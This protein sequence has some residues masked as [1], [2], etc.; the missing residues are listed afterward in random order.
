MYL[1]LYVV[2]KGLLVGIGTFFL[3][4]A[5]SSSVVS[6]YPWSCSPKFLL[7]LSAL[8]SVLVAA[9][10]CSLHCKQILSDGQETDGIVITALKVTL[11][12]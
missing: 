11:I 3:S 9:A 12:V 6:R 7:Y 8:C 4:G 1:R 10:W 2:A 5:A